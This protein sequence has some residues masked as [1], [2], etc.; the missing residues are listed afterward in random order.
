MKALEGRLDLA[1][2]GEDIARVYFTGCAPSPGETVR[3][4]ML[5][6]PVVEEYRED[7]VLL[8]RTFPEAHGIGVVVTMSGYALRKGEL[9]PDKIVIEWGE[10][11]NRMVIKLLTVEP[12]T[13][14]LDA[15]ID[16]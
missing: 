11:G 13:G 4:R 3:C 12:F 5:G 6:E 7:G 14:N 9:R 2:V 16:L 8:R 15:L 1:A 10:G